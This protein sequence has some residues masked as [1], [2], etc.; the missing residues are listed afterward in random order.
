MAMT[1]SRRFSVVVLCPSHWRTVMLKAAIVFFVIAII[2][3]VLGFGGLA[4]TSA[5]IAKLAF[6]VFIVLALA[7]FVFGRRAVSA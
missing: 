7:S 3:A 1:P 2:A 6:V 5:S 4:D